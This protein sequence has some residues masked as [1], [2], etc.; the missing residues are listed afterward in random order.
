[1][2]NC[3]I[4]GA[5]RSGTSMV[6]GTLADAGYY[7]G[8]TLLPPTEGNPKGY[9]ESREVEAVND[10]LIQTMLR[11]TRRERRLAWL[12]PI[13]QQPNFEALEPWVKARW[14]ALIPPI[15][16]PILKPVYREQIEALMRHQPFCFKDPRFSYTLPAWRPFLNTA[17]ASRETAFICV[18]REPTITAAS[19]L[20][21]VQNE[22]YLDGLTISYEQIMQ[23]WVY[24]YRHILTTHR[25]E[26]AWLF[27]HYNQVLTDDG[28]T[29]IET[30]L[31]TKV[32]RNFPE[33]RL[34]R[35]QADQPATRVAQRI[36]QQ[37]CKLAGHHSHA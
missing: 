13:P 16:K 28:L 8:D 15:R 1:M 36:Y 21:E 3:I 25:H 35:T 19:I 32:N 5:G 26:G 17:A 4:L 24:S 9:F 7:M 31:D 18:F 29:R 20:K 10:G 22:S 14:L 12:R 33:A 27:L 2:K 34:Q 37:L 23:I 30:L 6:A 11:P